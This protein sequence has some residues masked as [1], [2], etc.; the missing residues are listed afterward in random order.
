MKIG[1]RKMKKNYYKYLYVFLLIATIS[2]ELIPSSTYYDGFNL[3]YE[4][5]TVTEIN[6]SYFDIQAFWM[7]N[8]GAF[9]AAILSLVCLLLSVFYVYKE[10]FFLPLRVFLLISFFYSIIPLAMSYVTIYGIFISGLLA[11]NFSLTYLLNDEEDEED[12]FYDDQI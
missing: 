7:G 6:C 10:K 11:G 2:L 3:N 4:S 12:Y 8:F 9:T 1:E 5:V